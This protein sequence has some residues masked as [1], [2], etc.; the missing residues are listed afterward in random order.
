MFPHITLLYHTV[1]VQS[2]LLQIYTISTL[3]NKQATILTVGKVTQV[4]LIVVNVIIW[5]SRVLCEDWLVTTCNLVEMRRCFCGPC[6]MHHQDG[7]LWKSLL[8]YTRLYGVIVLLGPYVSKKTD[9]DAILVACPTSSLH[10]PW[11]H[12]NNTAQSAVFPFVRLPPQNMLQTFKQQ[13]P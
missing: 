11:Q 8:F 9:F 13:Q 6:C 3:A 12:I 5:L 7:I 2:S 10:Q 1:T 4:R